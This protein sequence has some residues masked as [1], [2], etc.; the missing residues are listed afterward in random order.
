[1]YCNADIF[2]FIGPFLAAGL[3]IKLKGFGL[4]LCLR[5]RI[6]LAMRIV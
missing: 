3:G 5:L 6:S 4:V 2:L 1:M